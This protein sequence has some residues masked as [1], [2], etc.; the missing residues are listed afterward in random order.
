MMI[1]KAEA[2]ILIADQHPARLVEMARL[3]TQD[4]SIVAALNSHRVFA[5]MAM[6]L[7]AHLIV[8][9]ISMLCLDQSMVTRHLRQPGRR[10]KLVLLI[11]EEDSGTL[12]EA[13]SLFPDGFVAKTRLDSDLIPVISAVLAGGTVSP[14]FDCPLPF[15]PANAASSGGGSARAVGSAPKA[16]RTPMPNPAACLRS[17]KH[18]PMQ[19]TW[20]QDV[21]FILNVRN[22]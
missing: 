7:D 8:L 14:S 20:S 2:R 12:N 21:A 11:G 17:G 10:S 6:R 3:A 5:E 18:R 22:K 4:Y 15:V 16:S 13:Q 19:P 1:T 9:D